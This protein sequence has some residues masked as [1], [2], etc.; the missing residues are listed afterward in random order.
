VTRPQPSITA[1]GLGPDPLILDVREPDEWAAGHIDGAI[2]I[3]LAS[4]ANRMLT[5]PGPLESD[6]PIVVT[7]KAG[8]RASQAA[9]W[10]NANGFAAVVLH[11]GMLG[12][13]ADG[14]PMVSDSGE[15]PTIR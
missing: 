4:V 2:G 7:C 6:R 12:W 15:P 8:G 3:P 10:L 14:R 5:A 9:E 1:D 13:Q 11:G